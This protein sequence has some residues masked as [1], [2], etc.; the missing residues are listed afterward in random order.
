[1][2]LTSLLGTGLRERIFSIFLVI[3]R[4]VFVVLLRLRSR[5]GSAGSGGG[6]RAGNR[7]LSGVDSK[8]RRFSF[9]D[10]RHVARIGWRR[11]SSGRICVL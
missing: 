2:A 10:T 4:R 5:C 7:R 8:L 6:G 3:A 9:A 1:M 11:R